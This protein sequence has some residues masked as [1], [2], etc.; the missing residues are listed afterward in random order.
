MLGAEA[1]R[2]S[3]AWADDALDYDDAVRTRLRGAGWTWGAVDG[4]SVVVSLMEIRQLLVTKIEA[5]LRPH[6]LS[7][8]SYEIL[9]H[10]RFTQALGLPVSVLGGA[11]Q[12]HPTSISNCLNQLTTAGFVKTVRPAADRRVVLCS[13]TEAG[14]AQTE[15]ATASLNTLIFERIGLTDDQYTDLFGG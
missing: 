12:V 3:V 5:V 13:L 9:M 10:L 15:C 2:V 14:R 8:A 7:F 11:L 6:D 1:S 4:Y